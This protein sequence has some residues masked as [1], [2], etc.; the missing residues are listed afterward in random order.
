MKKMY[1]MFVALCLAVSISSIASAGYRNGMGSGCGNCPQNGGASEQFHKFQ[2]DTIDLRQEMMTKRFAIQRENLH[3]TPDKDKV[4]ALQAEINSIQ[5]KIMDIRAQSGL[6]IN[7]CNGEYRRGKFKNCQQPMAGCN[8]G[9]GGGMHNGVNRG[10]GMGNCGNG[11]C[12]Q[13]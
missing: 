12:G 9:M 8:K 5:T 13:M 6:P 10:K 3:A 7:K 4:A 11:P 2:A 1:V